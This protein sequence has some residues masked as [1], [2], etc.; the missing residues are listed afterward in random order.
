MTLSRA[1]EAE[2]NCQQDEHVA[3]HGWR[4]ACCTRCRLIKP[5]QRGIDHLWRTA[6]T[7]TLKHDTTWSVYIALHDNASYWEHIIL[8]TM[9]QRTQCTSYSTPR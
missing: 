3:G 9:A 5:C 8:H 4:C 7:I 2:C 6:D 1:S